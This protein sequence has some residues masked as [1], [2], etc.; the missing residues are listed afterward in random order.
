M[1]TG[2]LAERSIYG[3]NI[4]ITVKYSPYPKE[5]VINTGDHEVIRNYIHWCTVDFNY[6]L[7]K[8]LSTDHITNIIRLLE[9]NTSWDWKWKW[10]MYQELLYRNEQI[11]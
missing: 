5:I 2:R 6:I 11:L 7:I 10:I 9:R 8:D 3:N 1:K 4:D